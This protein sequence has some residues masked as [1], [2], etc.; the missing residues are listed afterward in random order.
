MALFQKKP[1]HTAVA[2]L[3]TFGMQSVVLIVGLGNIGK[4]YSQ[5]RHNIGFMC[6]DAYV[7]SHDFSVWIEKKDLQC[8]LSEG[9]VADTKVILVKP[10][11]MMNLSG[12]SIQRVQQ[13][14]KLTNRQTLVIH[15]ELDIKFGQIRTRLGG[16]S[17]GNNGIK[18]MIENVGEDFGRVRIG[19]GPKQPQRME[20]ADFVLQDFSKDS[21]D[22]L[23][24]IIK[25]ALSIIDE[26][27]ATK[28]VKEE[29]RTVVI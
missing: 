23:R 13:F 4:Q 24:L 19:I 3:Y 22:N 2:N 28:E 29:T 12:I 27:T 20:A 18:S 15:D 25:E 21:H 14:Y 6:L 11:T 9:M 5:N 1:S 8:Y 7:N 17:A 26:F 10:T 16:S